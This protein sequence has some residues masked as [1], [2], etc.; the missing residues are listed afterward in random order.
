MFVTSSSG[1]ESVL[2]VRSLA[3]HF[4]GSWYITWLSLNDVFT[5]IAGYAF[6][7]T[8]LYGS[9]DFMYAY[10]AAFFGLPHS[11]NSPT[12]SGSVSSSIV[13]MTST[14]GTCAITAL[15]RS[16]RMLTTAP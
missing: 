14:N 4:A 1:F 16:G 3:T 7:D 5:S 10:S 15:N 2:Y 12:V 11:S 6:F 8:L 9:Y 13:L